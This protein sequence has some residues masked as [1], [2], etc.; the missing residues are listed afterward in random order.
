MPDQQTPLQSSVMDTDASM[1]FHDQAQR[2][3]AAMAAQC[4][5]GLGSMSPSVYDT[6]W[7]SMARN[8]AVGWLFPECFD[9]VLQLQLPSGAWQSYATPLDGILNTGAALLALKKHL[10]SLQTHGAEQHHNTDV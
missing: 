9:W 4:T 7:V 1:S 3:L 5:E 6:A 8:P 10:D 2:L